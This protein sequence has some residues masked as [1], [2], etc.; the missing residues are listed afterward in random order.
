MKRVLSLVLI[1]CMIFAAVPI[2]VLAVEVQNNA[3]ANEMLFENVYTS[4]IEGYDGNFQ[5]YIDEYSGYVYK[6]D[7]THK[8]KTYLTDFPVEN[9]I[10]RDKVLYAISNNKIIEMC[11]ETFD[12]TVIIQ[13]ADNIDRF[14]LHEDVLFYLSGGTLKKKYYEFEIT[15]ADCVNDFWLENS[16]ILSYMIDDEYIYSLD[17]ET[18]EMTRKINN[19]T[20][21]GDVIPIGKADTVE[22]FESV[23]SLRNKFPA[24]KYWN[25]VG[26]TN[27]PDGYTNTGCASHEKCDYYPNKC[28]CNSFS[29]AIQCHGFALK[30]AYDYYDTNPRTWT[31][32]EDMTSIKA[33]DVV[34]CNN[35]EHSIWVIKVSGNTVTYADCNNKGNCNIR[36]DATIKKTSLASHFTYLLSAPNNT[37]VKISSPE[38]NSWQDPRKDIVIKWNAMEGAAGYKVAVKCDSGVHEGEK[39]YDNVWTTDT[40][41]TI[42]YG[43]LYHNERYKIW[44]GGYESKSASEAMSAGDS[45]SINIMSGPQIEYPSNGYEYAHPANT[46]I[47]WTAVKSADS[48]LITLIN[49]DTGKD[50]YRNKDVGNTLS[51]RFTNLEENTTYKVAIGTDDGW[52]SQGDFYFATSK[53]PVISY[54]VNN[55]V[56]ESENVTV[57]WSSVPGAEDYRLILK[58]ESG[59]IVSGYNEVSTNGKTSYTATGLEKGE[60]YKVNVYG[61]IDE[62]GTL[63]EFWGEKTVVF[64]VAD[65]AADTGDDGDKE[66]ES[67]TL[68]WRD[69]EDGEVREYTIDSSSA[70]PARPYAFFFETSSSETPI[71]NVSDGSVIK[72]VLGDG[73]VTVTGVGSGNAT[74]TLTVGGKCISL[75]FVI[76]DTATEAETVL[77]WRN[78]EDG[79][80]YEC[81]VDLKNA[82]TAK[83]LILYYETN[84][85]DSPEVTSSD[86]SVIN[87]VL[88]GSCVNVSYVGAGS[89]TLTLTINDVSIKFTV[90]V[91]DIN[92]ENA[93]LVDSGTD[94]NGINWTL[95]INGVLKFSGTGKMQDYADRTES[96]FYNNSDIKIVIVED[97]VTSM[98]DYV[99]YGCENITSV[100]LAETIESIGFGSLYN[101]SSVENIYLPEN[102]CEIGS[103]A[104]YGCSS[105]TEV[106]IPE[107]VSVIPKRCFMKCESLSNVI[108]H[109]NI[110]EI[111]EDAFRECSSLNEVELPEELKIMG[112]YCFRD[113]ASLERLVVTE[114]VVT[115][116]KG[117][118]R[119]CTTLE[120]VEFL[121]SMEEISDDMFYDCGLLDNVLLPVGIEVIGNTAFDGCEKL[122]DVYFNG[123]ESEWLTVVVGDGNE[124]L[125]NAN[126]HYNDSDADKKPFTIEISEDNLEVCFLITVKEK[127][128]IYTAEYEDEIMTSASTTPVKANETVSITVEKT[129]EERLM[130]IFIWSDTLEPLTEVVERT[131][132]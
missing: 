18:N 47:K 46:T 20:D 82:T 57:K 119:G 52:W 80:V 41:F 25:H 69:Y 108:L 26:G 4:D 40:S 32:L 14:A 81:E 15:I 55:G 1:A 88:N 126:V 3:E 67:V 23:D 21:L 120:E 76:T 72:A 59:N 127:C 60:T 106:V 99:L 90:I 102:I 89:S 8:E 56:C 105:L 107:S 27:N 124:S 94:A 54:P 116:G 101:C 49:T 129:G 19:Q 7:T 45:I 2:G 44:V 17:I 131:I 125:T 68:K 78:Y 74:L 111:G 53:L 66:E 30:L 83:P 98:G 130:K 86:N 93:E 96:P 70:R 87:A 62:D 29:N 85:S 63:Q 73:R 13:C 114:N 132:K 122:S 121:N 36:W 95:D 113:C 71:I 123:N 61:V 31:K 37:D 115:M 11:L 75:N 109:D 103:N 110:T 5:Y 28:D 38:N 22:L 65:D 12:T 91:T 104:F 50:V 35:N 6:T 34:R 16:K 117:C 33:G 51:Y 48:Y 64:T 10:V 118:F 92:D 9:L 97:D 43:T 128:V 77:A 24:G 84:S 39:P 58:D 42:P 100:S 79:Y 112:K